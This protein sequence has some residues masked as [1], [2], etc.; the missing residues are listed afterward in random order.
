MRFVNIVIGNEIISKIKAGIN[1][2]NNGLNL[3]GIILNIISKVRWYTVSL[4]RNISGIISIVLMPIVFLIAFFSRFLKKKYDIGIGPVPLI[5]HVYFKKALES[6]GYSVQTYVTDLYKITNE[7]D[8]IMI[9]G[10]YRR[11]PFLRLFPI[12]F[13]YKSLY[14]YFDGGVLANRR[15]YRHLEAIIYKVAGIKTVVMTYGS[16]SIIPER[17]PNICFRNALFQDYSRFY[18]TR[19]KRIVWQVEYWCRY[20]DA[21]IAQADDIEY[22]PYWNYA[23]NSVFCVDL[24]RL[25]P[26]KD[27]QF[28]IGG[29]IHIVHA[30]NHMNIKGSAFIENAIQR[31]IK[32]GYDIQYDCLHKK[33]NKEV[34]EILEDADIVVDQII[35]G[36]HGIF[37]LESMAFGKPTITYIREDILNAYEEIGCLDKGELPLINA[38]PTSIYAVLRGL[39][40]DPMKLEEIGIKSRAYV[41]KRHSIKAIGEY[42]AEIN[43]N[44]G[45]IPITTE[46]R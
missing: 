40:D 25:K 8:C 18:R 4:I 6:Q 13:K 30:P 35:G 29:T 39:L 28:H 16:D 43:K 36:W 34:L 26:R 2:V 23:K 46:K 14:L 41:E 44:I 22:L 15:I 42:F 1:A 9:N 31:L 32:D 33:T 19:H 7:F 5:S 10:F 45:I 20:G 37:A 3:K 21:I 17:S 38:T 27:F 24:E 11:F 12:L